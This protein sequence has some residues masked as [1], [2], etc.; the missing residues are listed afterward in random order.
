VVPVDT[1]CSQGIWYI[2]IPEENGYPQ[3]ADTS[4]GIGPEDT[5]PRCWSMWQIV[6]TLLS[7]N[8]E[9]ERASPWTRASGLELLSDTPMRHHPPYYLTQTP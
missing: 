1:R 3:R 6:Q 8:A 5:R 7:F 2:T 4:R 9:V